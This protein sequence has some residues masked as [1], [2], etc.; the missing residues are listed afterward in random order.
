MAAEL[1]Q[2]YYA[3]YQK[4]FLL[5]IAKPY[6]NPNLTIFF[7]NS[8][9]KELVMQTTATK[10]GVIS[11]KLYQKLRWNLGKP[12]FTHEIT[13]EVIN[14][15]YDVLPFTRNSEQHKTLEAL[16]MWHPGSVSLLTKIV[17]G[18]GKKMPSQVWPSIYQNAFMAK[19]EIY[20]DYVTDYL[21]PA[22]DLIQN[23]AEIYRLATADSNYTN[24]TK[25]DCASAEELQ[26]K[27]GMPYYPFIP[28]I[29]ERL[30]SIY[31]HNKK[32]NVTFIQ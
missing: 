24:L 25:K 32:I 13:E 12:R 27:I 6:Y 8:V 2:I 14:S 18:I 29:L 10:V 7:E 28:F 3:D 5:P 19:T 4:E 20:Q 15:E 22:M 26:A 23:D 31:I 11:W 21:S 17:E 9:I 30:F 1:N 16:E